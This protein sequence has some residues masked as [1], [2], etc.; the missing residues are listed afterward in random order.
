MITMA[1]G[2][3]WHGAA[4][5]YAVWGIYHGLLLALERLARDR[6]FVWTRRPWPRRLWVFSLVTLGWL[7][8]RLPEF[9]QVLGFIEGVMTN[10]WY[11]GLE[12]I[13]LVL[14]YCLPVVFYHLAYLYLPKNHYFQF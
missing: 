4:W 12:R 2:G 10:E 5:S 11:G 7:L 9:G 1:L 14:I 13:P 3:L 6:G 8:F